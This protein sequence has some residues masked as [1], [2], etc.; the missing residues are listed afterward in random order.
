MFQRKNGPNDQAYSVRQSK[1]RSL[2][3]ALESKALSR[4]H[5][6]R[7]H[8][9]SSPGQYLFSRMRF[10]TAYVE[11]SLRAAPCVNALVRALVVHGACISH[12]TNTLLLRGRNE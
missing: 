9:V 10:L 3:N 1:R 6:V 2:R 11:S 7:I 12:Q 4:Q 5:S 8:E